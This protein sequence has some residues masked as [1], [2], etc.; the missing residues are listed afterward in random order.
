MKR[1]G[2]TH[3]GKLAANVEIHDAG[4]PLWRRHLNLV[5]CGEGGLGKCHSQKQRDSDGEVDQVMI[6]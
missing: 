6:N 3:D 2:A 5:P 1:R 4:D